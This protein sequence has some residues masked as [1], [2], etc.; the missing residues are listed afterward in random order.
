MSTY[1]L[2]VYL[3]I[4]VYSYTIVEKEQKENS[5]IIYISKMY[6]M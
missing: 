6:K 1:V 3:Y 4:L 2:L 5:T